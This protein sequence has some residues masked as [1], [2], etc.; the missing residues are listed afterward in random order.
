MLISLQFDEDEVD[1]ISA[2]EHDDDDELD[3]ILNARS[4]N[5]LVLLI[6]Y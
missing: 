2:V 6:V 3:D 5:Y 4:L 1:D